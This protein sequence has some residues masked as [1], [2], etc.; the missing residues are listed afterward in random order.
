[1]NITINAATLPDMQT[2][3]SCHKGICRHITASFKDLKAFLSWVSNCVYR[4]VECF[5]SQL[6][7][8]KG[9]IWLYDRLNFLLNHH[10]VNVKKKLFAQSSHAIDTNARYTETVIQLHLWAK[11]FVLRVV[12]FLTTHRYEWEF[13]WAYWY[14][15]TPVNFSW[16]VILHLTAS[17]SK[18]AIRERAEAAASFQQRPREMGEQGQMR[19]KGSN[20]PQNADTEFSVLDSHLEEFY[21]KSLHWLPKVTHL[22][23]TEWKK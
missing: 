10:N 7:V 1:M 5:C 19:R 13:R 15:S 22:S 6:A 17:H 21:S 12:F 20:K 11:L 16:R 8:L 14:V 4:A 3:L 23:R 9:H 18:K 2:F